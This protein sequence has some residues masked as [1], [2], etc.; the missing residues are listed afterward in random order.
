[1]I[2]GR[3]INANIIA[4]FDESTGENPSKVAHP[5]WLWREFAGENDPALRKV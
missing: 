1:L 3:R 4:E 5:A 2:D